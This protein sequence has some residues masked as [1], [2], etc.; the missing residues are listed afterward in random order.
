MV[1]SIFWKVKSNTGTPFPIKMRCFYI[2]IFDSNTFLGLI[3]Y[4]IDIKKYEKE[5]VN[6]EILPN[7]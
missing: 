1:F 5:T 4:S 6:L 7:Q 3:H 2:K